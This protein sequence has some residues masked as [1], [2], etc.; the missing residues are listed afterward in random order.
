MLK[1][2]SDLISRRPLVGWLTFFAIMMV[3]FLIGLLAASITERRAEIATLLANRKIEIKD[4]EGRNDVWGINFP[5]QYE[6]WKSSA[7]MDFKSK[8]NSNHFEDLLE[9][10]PNLVVLWAGLAFGVDYNAPR[11]HMHSVEDLYNTLRTGGPETLEENNQR[12]TCWTCKSSDLPRMIQQVGLDEFNSSPWSKYGHEVVNPIGCA[13]CHDAKTMELTITRPALIKAFEKQGR[14]ISSAS[15][16]EMRSLVCAQCHVEYYF[17]KENN[18]IIFPWKHGFS[19][20]E[21]ERHLDEVGHTD[22][23]HA[24]SKA[25]MI[26]PQHPDYELYLYG[27]HAKKGVSCADCHMPYVAEGGVK[28]SSHHV[29]SPLRNI[30]RTCLTCHRDSEEN[31]KALVYSHQDK[32]AEIRDM[33]EPEL[34]K[35][36]LMAKHAWESG[37]SEAQM[38]NS[39]QLIRQAQWRWDFVVASH[40]AAFHAPVESQRLFSHALE[41]TFKAQIELTKILVK[42]GAN[43][44]IAMPDISTKDKAQTFIGQDMK[45]RREK[46]QRFIQ[47]VVPGWLKTA[48]EN[49][50][51]SASLK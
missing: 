46:K 21:Q 31:L 48:M 41:R 4:L 32:L 10:R 43:P 15:V 22:W 11:G 6:T 38:A 24:L 20:E 2:L 49:N 1:K 30:G 29:T 36:H 17:G 3:V 16:Q 40:G 25:P 37:A 13:D 50:R 7:L 35:T 14:D 8:H 28:F 27:T 39:L 26:K 42:L 23:V 33:L 51:L 9:Q 45:Q 18:P 34:V 5:R 44:V 19:G 47:N 12:G